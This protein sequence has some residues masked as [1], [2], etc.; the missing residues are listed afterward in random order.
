[1]LRSDVYADPESDADF[2]RVRAGVL[3][4]KTDS[5]DAVLTLNY[6]S[7]EVSALMHNARNIDFDESCAIVDLG[8]RGLLGDAWQFSV[9]AIYADWANQGVG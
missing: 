5:V 4:R 9:L 1:M 2:Y 7:L 3:R 6:V 8:L